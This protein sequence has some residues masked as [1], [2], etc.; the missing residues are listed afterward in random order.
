[1]SHFV[2][3]S[4]EA[5]RFQSLVVTDTDPT[6]NTVEWGVVATDDDSSDDTNDPAAWVAGS[7]GTWNG[8]SADAISPT[9]GVSGAGITVVAGN[10]YFV[11]VRVSSGSDVSGSRVGTVTVR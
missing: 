2:L 6:G 8:Y 9:I 5:R 11:Y 1:M 10:T 4:W 7:W 3:E